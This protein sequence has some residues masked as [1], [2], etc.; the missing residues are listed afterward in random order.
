MEND[1]HHRPIFM[2][3]TARE[4]TREQSS[5]PSGMNGYIIE[6]RSAE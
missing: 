5:P 4:A 2:R 6:G 3:L 1:S